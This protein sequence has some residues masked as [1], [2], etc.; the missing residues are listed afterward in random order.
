MVIWAQP[1]ET[2][3]A[4]LPDVFKF[5]VPSAILFTI[6]AL[7]VY[8]LFYVG[9]G[10]GWIDIVYTDA[11]L[12]NLFWSGS[13]WDDRVAAE[14]EINARNAMLLFLTLTGVLQLLFISPPKKFFSVDGNVSHDIK[15]AVL[16]LL[17]VLLIMTAYTQPAVMEFLRIALLG[18]YKAIVFIIAAVWFFTARYI[19]RKGEFARISNTAEWVYKKAL[20]RESENVMDM[21]IPSVPEEGDKNI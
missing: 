16:V 18:D 14:Q 17:L 20:K 8:I 4:L 9:T 3:G 6:F 7:I 11:E 1:G 12:D 13:N 19:L 10:Y 2:K 5:A 21:S 15:P